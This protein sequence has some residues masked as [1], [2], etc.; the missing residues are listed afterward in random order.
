[1]DSLKA[2]ILEALA[3]R[4]KTI[5]TANHY[6]TNVVN[7]YYDKIPMGI[8]LN[9]YQLPAI[10]IISKGDILETKQNTLEGNWELG[11]QLWHTGKMGDFVM[12]QF[13]RDVYKAIYANSPTAQTNDS[14]RIH[15]Q[16][17]ELK[18]VS[19]ISD[20]NM[21]EANRVYEVSF[22]IKYRTKL[23]NL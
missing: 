11:L 7:V 5:T 16:V 1:M 8:E 14:F 18:P 21:I 6:T 10:F 3:N 15:P 9:N 19:I 13:T 12:D 23:F 20:L 4:L 22:L 17:V 2:N